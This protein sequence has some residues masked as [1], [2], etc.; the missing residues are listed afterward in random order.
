[1]PIQWLLP[2]YAPAIQPGQILILGSFFVIVAR[3]PIAI[4]VSLNRQNRLML[5]SLAAVLATATVDWLLLKSGFGI[6]GVAAGSALGF[7][8]YAAATIFFTFRYLRLSTKKLL[9]FLLTLI[10]PFLVM[11]AGIV[12]LDRVFPSDSTTW[13][14][15]MTHAVIRVVIFLIPSGFLLFLCSHRFRFLNTAA[16][17]EKGT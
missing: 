7:M 2:Q 9:K 10:A 14:A 12:V 15:D 17:V 13:H 16:L 1:L 6:S 4:M 5:I 3:M 11:V 8:L